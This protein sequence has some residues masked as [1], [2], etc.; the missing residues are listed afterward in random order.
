[1]ITSLPGCLA[2]KPGSAALPFLGIVPAVVD[3]NG[4]EIEGPAQ[5]HLVF[6]KPWPGM[7][8]TID[9][10]HHLF[11]MTYFHK[12][13]KYYWTGDGV[14]RDADGYYWITGRNDDNLNVSGHLLSSVE[15]E[16]AIVEHRAVAEAAV[17]SIPHPVK[18]ES[19][20]V[21]VVLNNGHQLTLELEQSIKLRGIYIQ[22]KTVRKPI[23]KN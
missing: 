12:F 3:N 10:N 2:M 21:F 22:I 7:A 5:G 11:E 23:P 20:H 8:R 4:I 13:L 16:T 17:V 18:G 1:M 14:R 9:G 15:I 19:L 6:K